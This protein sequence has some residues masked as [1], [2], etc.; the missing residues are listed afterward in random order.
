MTSYPIQ[1]VAPAS[2]WRLGEECYHVIIPCEPPPNPNSTVTPST[3]CEESQVIYQVVADGL[4]LITTGE[5]YTVPLSVGDV[6]QSFYALNLLFCKE[7]SNKRSEGKLNSGRRF[8]QG[9]FSF[10]KYT[11]IHTARVMKYL[12]ESLLLY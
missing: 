12:C 1:I 6:S 7:T 11:S 5:P 10:T 3:P 8:L 4:Q 2:I 9:R